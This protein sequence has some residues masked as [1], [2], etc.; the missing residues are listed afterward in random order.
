MVR[1]LC[2]ALSGGFSF[3]CEAGLNATNREDD[4]EQPPAHPLLMRCPSSRRQSMPTPAAEGR[5]GGCVSMCSGPVQLSHA[6]NILRNG[7]EPQKSPSD[8]F[9]RL[10]SFDFAQDDSGYG[11]VMHQRG[12]SR[13][14]RCAAHVEAVS[15]FGRNDELSGFGAVS[16]LGRNRAGGLQAVVSS[17]SSGDCSTVRLSWPQAA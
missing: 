1:R 5:P 6:S 3:G 10:R 13:L 12:Y 15:S 14:L 9:N 2:R 17:T 8:P 4:S 11:K 7:E 16:G